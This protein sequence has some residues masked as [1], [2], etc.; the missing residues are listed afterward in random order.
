MEIRGWADKDSDALRATGASFTSMTGY[1][2]GDLVT[3]SG[4]AHL[5]E[6]AEQSIAFAASIACPPSTCTAPGWATRGCPW[7]P[8]RSSPAGCG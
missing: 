4:V 3:D 7:F 5:L 6:T 8:W 1:L 2:E